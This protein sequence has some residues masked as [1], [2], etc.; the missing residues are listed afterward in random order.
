MMTMKR[1]LLLSFAFIAIGSAGCSESKKLAK[2]HNHLLDTYKTLQAELPEAKVS[3]QGD[4]VKVILPEAVMFAVNKSDITLEYL[5]VM[6][7]I[8]GIL[9]KYP[10][11]NILITGY[12]DITGTLEYNNVLSIERANST[13]GVLIG[14]KVKANRIFTWGLGPKNPIADND[15]EVGRKQNRRVEFVVLYDY[16]ENT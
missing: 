11:T 14:N 12:T 4:K 13:K 5:P 9:N 2:Q 6:K 3:M 1:I 16:E 7:R 10:K 15:T 8:A